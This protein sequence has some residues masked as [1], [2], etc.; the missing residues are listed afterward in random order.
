MIHKG[1]V[2][3]TI[4]TIRAKNSTRARKASLDEALEPKGDGKK[5]GHAKQTQWMATGYPFKKAAEPWYP[6]WYPMI[7]CAH[8][9]ARALRMIVS[10]CA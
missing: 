1:N 8:Q 3:S 5:A 2:L 9:C 6:V 10:R 7:D 4:D